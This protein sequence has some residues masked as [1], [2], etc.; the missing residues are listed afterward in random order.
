MAASQVK[1]RSDDRDERPAQRGSTFVNQRE[2]RR[3][4]RHK[5]RRQ[6]AEPHGGHTQQRARQC[7]SHA[8]SHKAP[9]LA[10]REH[11][12]HRRAKHGDHA[13]C[14]HA[15]AKPADP[16]RRMAVCHGRADCCL[17]DEDGDRIERSPTPQTLRTRQSRGSA[18]N[19]AVPA[20]RE[21]QTAA[22]PNGTGW[23]PAP[24]ARTQAPRPRAADA[25]RRATRR[26][27]PML[28]DEPD[29]KRTDRKLRQHEHHHQRPMGVLRV[30]AEVIGRQQIARKRAPRFVGR[31]R[32]RDLRV[33]SGW[34]ERRRPRHRRRLVLDRR[35]E[36]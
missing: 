1:L 15:P 34:Q 3:G 2:K 17:S 14:G 30:H 21:T 26:I 18:T 29:E 11:I 20:R 12:D 5:R 24:A 16:S 32:Q 22:A 35:G 10:L 8:D 6:N 7:K 28:Q 27:K 19:G 9:A 25:S 36:S 23:P 33:R 4:W 31:R 13:G